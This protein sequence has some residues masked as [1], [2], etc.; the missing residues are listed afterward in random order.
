[1]IVVGY[2]GGS[3]KGI[4]HIA[5]TEEIKKRYIPDIIAV[6]SISAILS[7]PIALYYK[8]NPTPLQQ[9]KEVFFNLSPNDIWSRQ[10]K[11]MSALWRFIRKGYLGEMGNLEKHLRRIVTPQVYR[12]YLKGDYPDIYI[13]TVNEDLEKKKYY[14]VKGL[15]YED[16]IKVVMASASIP[17]Y[18]PA[19]KHEGYNLVDGGVMDHSPTAYVLGKYKDKVKLCISCYTREAEPP[20]Y[21]TQEIKNFLQRFFNKAIYRV[22][23][24]ISILLREVSLNDESTERDLCKH[25]SSVFVPIYFP[26]VLEDWYDTNINLLKR[27]YQLARASSKQAVSNI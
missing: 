15:G 23:K 17:I 4:G 9:C 19:I 20:P 10:P 18:T 6:N 8:N 11:G 22:E 14:S 24:T 7:I 25:Y 3:T 2:S 1:M 16:Y 26:H 21:K 12:D 27:L 5:A 13:A